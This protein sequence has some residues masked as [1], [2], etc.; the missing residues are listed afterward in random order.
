MYIVKWVPTYLP[1]IKQVENQAGRIQYFQ[2]DPHKI[3]FWKNNNKQISLHNVYLS[4]ANS[5][6]LKTY[7][8]LKFWLIIQLPQV[9]SLTQAYPGEEFIATGSHMT[10]CNQGSFSKQPR[11]NWEWGWHDFFTKTFPCVYLNVAWIFF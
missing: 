1:C 7:Y 10:S 11:K 4:K 8:C 9:N 5:M 6:C 3:F 2:S